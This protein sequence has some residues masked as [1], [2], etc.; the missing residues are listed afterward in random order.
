MRMKKHGEI[1]LWTPPLAHGGNLNSLLC[2]NFTRRS[3]IINFDRG[4]ARVAS[5]SSAMSPTILCAYTDH[6]GSA[7]LPGHVFDMGNFY[8]RRPYSEQ[9]IYAER[10]I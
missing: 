3:A 4:C 8:S 5:N 7:P 1:L 9:F 2:H 6:C 10:I